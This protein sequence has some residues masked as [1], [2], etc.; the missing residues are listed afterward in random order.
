MGRRSAFSL[1]ELLVVIGI[2]A[3]LMSML[4]PSLNRAREQAKQV[5]CASQLR[6]VGNAM[7]GY[8]SMNRGF[9]PGWSGWQVFGDYGTKLDG[10]GDDEAGPGWTEELIPYMGPGTA[11]Y[12]CPNF[13]PE[14]TFNYFNSVCWIHYEQVKVNPGKT[15][16]Q[17]S[18]IKFASEFILSGD[19]NQPS[20]YPG[21]YLPYAVSKTAQ[22]ADHDDSTQ[23]GIL[24]FGD[25]TYGQN[26]HRSGNNIL[27]GDNHVAP[28]KHFDPELMTYDPTKPGQT[29][30]TVYGLSVAAP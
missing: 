19:C 10:T 27:F 28:Y 11:V 21:T 9:Y 6:Q 15:N 16:L 24:F 2:I 4:L 13:Q 25:D 18:D 8:A 7:M 22:D 3:V 12:H 1:V 23:K 30:E 14:Q 17:V 29:W 20:L 26:M 5:Q